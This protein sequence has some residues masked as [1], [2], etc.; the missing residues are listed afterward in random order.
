MYRCMC[1]LQLVIYPLRK[2]I[3]EQESILLCIAVFM[4]VRSPEPF[5]SDSKI[6]T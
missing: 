3:F 5:C 2:L 1:L 4:N 6:P